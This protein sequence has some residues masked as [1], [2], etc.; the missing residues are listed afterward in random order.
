MKGRT[1]VR[2][3]GILGLVF[4]LVIGGVLP[5]AAQT[6]TPTQTIEKCVDNAA[7]KFVEC[8][9]DLPSWAELLCASRYAADAIL[10]VPSTVLKLT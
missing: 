6:L 9:D 10:C 3:T 7:D 2:V 8:V 5:A 4:A 1:W